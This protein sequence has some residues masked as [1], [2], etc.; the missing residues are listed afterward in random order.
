[1][2]AARRQAQSLILSKEVNKERTVRGRPFSM[3]SRCVYEP[4][5]VQ[6]IYFDHDNV[7]S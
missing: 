3:L 6:I 4:A 7:A 1:L 2:D 5:K